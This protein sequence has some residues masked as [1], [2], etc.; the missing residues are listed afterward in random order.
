MIDYTRIAYEAY[1]DSTGGVNYQGLPMP[2]YEE[3]P[4]NIRS[5]WYAAVQAVINEVRK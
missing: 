2:K 3:L 4:S 1:V 5:A